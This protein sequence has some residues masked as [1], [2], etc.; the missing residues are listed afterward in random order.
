MTQLLRWF[1][2]ATTQLHYKQRRDEFAFPSLTK[3]SRGAI[4]KASH[5]DTPTATNSFAKVG[6]KW[7]SAMSD[8]NFTQVLNTVASACSINESVL[9]DKVWFT[10]HC[11]RRGGAR[12]RFVFAPE[13][14]R[15]SLKLVKPWAGWSPNQQNEIIVRYLL[16]DVLDREESQ[17][18]GLPRS[19]HDRQRARYGHRCDDYHGTAGDE[20]EDR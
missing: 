7:D 10:S 20:C 2:Y 4:K 6:I 8:N 1:D 3:I 11:F 17:L 19:G 9:G 18:G 14:R 12:Y 15:W 16:D 5:I 13:R